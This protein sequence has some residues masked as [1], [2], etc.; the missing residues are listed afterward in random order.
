LT[1]PAKLTEQ[2]EWAVKEY[3]FASK[4]EFFRQLLREWI[5]KKLVIIYD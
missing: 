3:N 2:V 4:S 1:L 5:A